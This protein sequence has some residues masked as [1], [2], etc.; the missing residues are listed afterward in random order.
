MN[1]QCSFADSQEVNEGDFFCGAQYWCDP[2]NCWWLGQKI[3]LTGGGGPV[4]VILIDLRLGGGVSPVKSTLC[5]EEE[6]TGRNC[7]VDHPPEISGTEL[8]PRD[9]VEFCIP[10]VFA[11]VQCDMFMEAM[12]KMHGVPS[13]GCGRWRFGDC[14]SGWCRPQCV[15]RVRRGGLELLSPAM[16]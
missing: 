8:A 2:A 16:K 6:C 13:E 10:H 5:W 14:L 9:L 1:E 4:S 12:R 3:T 7:Q 15:Q 11:F